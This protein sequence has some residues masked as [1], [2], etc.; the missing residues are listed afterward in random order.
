ME[1]CIIRKASN[2]A[3]NMFKGLL[4]QQMIALELLLLPRQEST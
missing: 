2:N 1:R 4:G 3:I